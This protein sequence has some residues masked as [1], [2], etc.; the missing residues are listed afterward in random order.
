MVFIVGFF[1]DLNFTFIRKTKPNRWRMN[2]YIVA[3]VYCFIYQ[4]ILHWPKIVTSFFSS[5]L[6]SNRNARKIRSVPKKEKNSARTHI[7]ARYIIIDIQLELIRA[8]PLCVLLNFARS[9]FNR[10]ISKCLIET[11]EPSNVSFFSFYY[12]VGTFYFQLL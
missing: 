10:T 11:V 3:K 1:F 2:A 9:L 8:T 7:H 6:L 5:L 4:N 12:W